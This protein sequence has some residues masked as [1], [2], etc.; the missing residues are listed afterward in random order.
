MAELYGREKVEHYYELQQFGKSVEDIRVYAN[1]FWKNYKKVKNWQKY[2]E[3][4]E[5]GELELEKRYRIDKAIEDKFAK[6]K[7]DFLEAN[8]EKTILD[9]KISDIVIKYEK[10]QEK[11]LFDW[12]TMED[13]ICA[14]GLYKFTYGFWDLIRNYFRNCPQ[15]KLNW[16]AQT[17]TLD[18]IHKRCDYLIQL[19][20]AEL[21]D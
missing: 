14:L 16:A 21:Y 10:T 6:L 5:K 12:T 15:L 18:D 17:R 19:F 20:R 1:A 8:P 13:Q 3:R 7:K 9:F 11:N 2:L 4:I